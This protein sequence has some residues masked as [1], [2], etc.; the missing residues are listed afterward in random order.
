MRHQA[1]TG[2]VENS[3]HQ[4]LDFATAEAISVGLKDGNP[5]Y[6]DDSHHAFREKRIDVDGTSMTKCSNKV[7][8]AS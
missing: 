4:K 7:R 1:D 5:K 2:M 6:T 3:W 8:T